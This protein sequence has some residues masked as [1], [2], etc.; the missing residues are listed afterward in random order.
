MTWA[1]SPIV[2]LVPTALLRRA[3][4]S[5]MEFSRSGRAASQTAERLANEQ[6][7][8]TGA[9]DRLARSTRRLTSAQ[10]RQRRTSRGV[11]GAFRELYGTS[12]QAL[13][14]TQ[15]LRSEVLAL[16]AAY[17]G[18]FAVF[19]GVSNIAEAGTVL[20]GVQNRLAVVF[21]GDQGQTAIEL[22]FLRR[23]ADRL[24]I[25]F[26]VLSQEYSKFA[27]ATQDTNLAGENTRRIFVAVAEAARVQNLSLDQIQGTFLALTQIVSKGVV[28]MGGAS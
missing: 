19:R 11:A 1:H 8:A 4:M 7:R 20:Q 18:L 27:I 2:R 9:T 16:T 26:Q 22:D 28:S 24:G 21:R 10:Q 23:N 13:S 25:S 15:R 14:F 12:R 17:F 6:R 3:S 5:F